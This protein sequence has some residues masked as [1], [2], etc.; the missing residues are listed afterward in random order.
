M[1]DTSNKFSLQGFNR[2]KNF[3]G[4]HA[5]R[6]EN[7]NTYYELSTIYASPQYVSILGVKT[8]ASGKRYPKETSV[9]FPN[10]EHPQGVRASGVPI[11]DLDT[12]WLN[13]NNA[14][15]NYKIGD[16]LEVHLGNNLIGMSLVSA[17]GVNG[18]ISKLTHFTDLETLNSNSSLPYLVDNFN[19]SASFSYNNKFDVIGVKMTS[20]GA[21]YQTYDANYGIEIEHDPVVYPIQATQ[22][23]NNNFWSTY[24]YGNSGSSS[25]F[26]FIGESDKSSQIF[27]QYIQSPRVCHENKPNKFS[28]DGE[29]TNKEFY[30]NFVIKNTILFNKSLGAP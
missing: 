16:Q 28:T 26:T 7:K 22:I 14:G 24:N 11:F 5:R 30:K 23:D 17:T 1:S 29:L 27:T 20:F 15:S 25:I 18:S 3:S 6:P 4:L 21:G 9:V 19:G 10:P 12:D 8:I 13:I 2:Q